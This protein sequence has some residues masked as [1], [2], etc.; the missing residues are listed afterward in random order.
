MEVVDGWLSDRKAKK[1]AEMMT[2]LEEAKRAIKR[3]TEPVTL[4]AMPYP[5][6]S[7]R[8][9]ATDPKITAA[10]VKLLEDPALG[11]VL[12][13]LEHENSQGAL[14]IYNNGSRVGVGVV[15]PEILKVLRPVPNEVDIVKAASQL[16][17]PV[18][19]SVPVT[20]TA[21]R[22]LTAVIHCKEIA[23]MATKKLE[24]SAEPKSKKFAAK[25]APVSA[26][27]PKPAK[28]EKPAKA[29]KAEKPA[30]AVKAEKAERAPRTGSLAGKKIKVISK[31]MS[32]LREGTKRY[33]GLGIILKSKTTDEAL[34]LLVKAG[35]NSTWFAFATAAGY[36][37]LV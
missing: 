1:T 25:T 9:G 34:P 11:I 18:V 29:S 5:I 2:A 36:V 32:A 33:I 17:N 21:A 30:K 31:D 19:P 10:S 28:A 37:E 4:S 26:A 22:H 15:P 35:C 7:P 3:V 6:A 23:T 20:P 14:V 16:L 13:Q 24:A 8:E 12:M 27:L